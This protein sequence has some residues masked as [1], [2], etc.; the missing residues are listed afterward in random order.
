M[1]SLYV[2]YSCLALL[3]TVGGL[4]AA[5][6][7]E[8][9]VSPAETIEIPTKEQLQAQLKEWEAATEIVP[10]LKAKLIELGK[11]ALEE[12]RLCQERATKIAE[13]EALESA[14]PAKHEQLRA[15][16]QV[17][18]V[19][20]KEIP[21]KSSAEME[22]LLATT[23]AELATFQKKLSELDNEP[24]RRNTRRLEI[25]K[26]SAAVTQKLDELN[27][28]AA[29]PRTD[30]PPELDKIRGQLRVVRQ[31]ALQT[32][33]ELYKRE[34]AYYDATG[35][36]LLSLERDVAARKVREHTELSSA[37][38][39][40]VTEQRR[41][42][43]EKQAAD[44]RWAAA[45]AEPSVRLIAE[46]NQKLA[47]Q[48]EL[49]ADQIEAIDLEAKDTNRQLSVVRE[50]HQ[51]VEDKFT[52]AGQS[53]AVGQLL[54]K[55]RSELPDPRELRSAAKARKGEISDI[56]L[57]I[58]DLEDRRRTLADIKELAESTLATLP[59][60]SQV[61]VD[62]LEVLM[63]TERDY[64]D[65]LIGDCDA[66]FKK[67]LELES[68]RQNLIDVTLS[69]SKYIDERVL[70][71][72]SAPA[73]G[74]GDPARAWEAI[75]W[76]V[77]PENW[78]TALTALGDE[79]LQRPLLTATVLL[80]FISALLI[81][82]R[83]RQT[84]RRLSKQASRPRASQFWPTAQAVVVTGILGSIWPLLLC[85]LGWNLSFAPDEF[86]S[87]LGAAIDVV[88]VVYWPIE[89]MRQALRPAGL[90]E[91]HFGWPPP[92]LHVIRHHIRILMVVLLPLVLCTALVQN[93]SNE[94]WKES[95]GRAAFSLTLLTL[96][97][98][99]YL[100]LRPI[101]AAITHKA[102]LPRKGLVNGL[103]LLWQFILVGSPV[104]LA[105]L[106][107]GGYYYTALRL[108]LRLQSTIWLAMAL[109]IVH[110]LLERWL[111]V[112][113]RRLETLADINRN[114]GESGEITA[115]TETGTVQL[116]QPE[117]DLVV[118]S[119]QTQRLLHSVTVL[120]LFAGAG[121]IWID[122]LP[123]LGI[124]NHVE[125]WTDTESNL[126]V[127]LASLCLSLLAIVMTFIAGRNIPGLLEISLLQRLPL[128][129]AARFAIITVS[130]Y[131]I[132]IVGTVLAFGSIGIGWSKVQ[133]LAAAITFG[134]GFGLQEIFANFISGLI[135][136]FE[137]PMRV[138]DTVTVDGVTGVVSRI[139]MRATTITDGD[140]KELIV[141]NKQFIT[142]RL[143]NWTL[144]DQVIRLV[145]RIGLPF[146]TDVALVQRIL[147]SAAQKHPQ[148]LD[149]PRP[150]A[151][152]T[153]FADSN[154][155]FELR[156]FVC[157]LEFMG[158]A[159]HELNTTIDSAL[160]SAGINLA[161]PTKDVNIRSV[162]PEV[163]LRISRELPRPFDPES[164]EDNS[165]AARA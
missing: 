18:E 15:R 9:E 163:P 73:I 81:Q 54:R 25:T 10:E 154:L 75:K 51:R 140:R 69:F 102:P 141:P 101:R 34:L 79:C 97:C 123:A 165:Y 114:C 71:I 127:T 106:A 28:E 1:K 8:V 130:R 12:S 23:A 86:S 153:G 36:A 62:Q 125:L 118:I 82:R 39:A 150:M 99:I 56:Q 158:T 107:L 37:L 60:N 80:A 129:P 33:L 84:I 64:L 24:K 6:A 7:Q 90:A 58:F 132:V 149:D 55:K 17:A 92:V 65:A 74:R 22:Q 110:A 136:L 85:Y 57:R 145:I 4:P 137:S 59:A 133:W 117:I 38:Q 94:M 77:S 21:R 72:Q 105:I 113:H 2:F 44:A 31:K 100:T 50:D 142:G 121:L 111:R 128:E 124:L 76:C 98:F 103:G 120:A 83:L 35:G 49:L 143:V 126:P 43:A 63:Q 108:A 131:I 122:V 40:M 160:R 5:S 134:L 109:L 162:S 26:A 119:A 147:L 27:K 161:S 16:M 61:T 104:S 151:L 93:Q 13:Y 32:E 138:G 164:P 14:A 91:A 70:W 30:E 42:E 45:K 20:V 47:E 19:N 96:A 152:F 29:V 112:A 157:S 48:R 135:I 155:T 115:V 67:L 87:A 68:V 144:S 46:G 53:N 146:G 89:L 159:Q 148:I 116:P 3:F 78:Q 52:A 139:H 88:T 11:Q 156:A 95:L 66:Y 41:Q